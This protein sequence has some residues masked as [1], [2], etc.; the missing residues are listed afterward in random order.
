V[1]IAFHDIL[2]ATRP[3]DG[4]KPTR[5]RDRRRPGQHLALRRLMGEEAYSLSAGPW[6]ATSD[7][8]WEASKAQSRLV[9]KAEECSMAELPG[10]K[11]AINLPAGGKLGLA[12]T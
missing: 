11:E 9:V 1:G 12:S 4:S 8:D 7:V 2:V 3:T 6:A 10:V 5:L